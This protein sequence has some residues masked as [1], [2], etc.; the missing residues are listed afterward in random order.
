MKLGNSGFRHE[1]TKSMRLSHLASLGVLLFAIGCNQTV[2][3]PIASTG[4]AATSTGTT[5]SSP[6]GSSTTNSSGTGTSSGS[7]SGGSG[8]ASSSGGTA[9]RAEYPIDTDAGCSLFAPVYSS[10]AQACVACNASNDSVCQ[11]QG[12]LCDLSQ[13]KCVGCL[14]SAN[15][16][17]PLECDPVA[18]ICVYPCTLDA[19]VCP[20]GSYCE[21]GPSC[22]PGCET[23]AQ[24]AASTP[25]CLVNFP[26]SPGYCVGCNP[27]APFEKETCPTGQLCEQYTC[28]PD[29]RLA[30]NTCGAGQFCQTESN[31][32]GEIAGTCGYGCLTSSDCGGGTCLL[33][34]GT[35]G[36][37][38]C[39]ECLANQDCQARGFT[40]CESSFT[41]DNGCSA[42]QACPA[43]LTCSMFFGGSEGYCGCVTNA[44]CVSA[45][46]DTLPTCLPAVGNSTIDPD[47][48]LY[49]FCGCDATSTCPPGLICENRSGPVSTLGISANGVCIPGC[50]VDGGEPCGLGEGSGSFLYVPPLCEVTTGYCVNCTSGSQCSPDA[51]TPVCVMG[52]FDA[53]LHTGGGTC[54][55]QT[56]SDCGDDLICLSG[57][58]GGYC[59]APCVY[60]GGFDSCYGFDELCNTFTGTCAGC[61]DNYDCLGAGVAGNPTPLCDQDAGSCVACLTKS[62]CGD[63][64]FCVQNAFVQCRTSTDC[65]DGESC[66]SGICY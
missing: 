12:L 41:C 40:T 23:D 54:G 28:V 64:G 20:S 2:T 60:D 44:D 16:G 35:E 45:L 7:T 31:D 19:G 63:A 43:A 27:L 51:R 47:A 58:P 10:T 11:L 3:I 55:C 18:E 66:Y 38:L 26:G 15:C 36:I 50:N 13:N 59:T 34:A 24:C 22:T 46:G 30:G 8:S 42:T 48:G 4:A 25:L 5:T 21:F 52:G 61:L 65:P 29:C 17:A 56:N 62:D 6:G 14:S 33:D 53:G 49:G 1:D 9:A 37:G 57:G 32:G 39:A